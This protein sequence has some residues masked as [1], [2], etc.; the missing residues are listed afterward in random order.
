[1]PSPLLRPAGTLRFISCLILL[2]VEF[3]TL[4][5][6]SLEQIRATNASKDMFDIWM[7]NE[8]TVGD[9]TYTERTVVLPRERYRSVCRICYAVIASLILSFAL[10]RIS[11]GSNNNAKEPKDA[12]EEPAPTAPVLSPPPSPNPSRPLSRQG[13]SQ[14]SN[15]DDDRSHPG[16]PVYEASPRSPIKQQEEPPQQQP[17]EERKALEIYSLVGNTVL[18]DEALRRLFSADESPV[19]D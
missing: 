12:K 16:S 17:E 11:K 6:H 4:P 1:M 3:G 15:A 10:G 19:A 18:W 8:F 13:S 2:F 9:T 14:D 7:S 5:S